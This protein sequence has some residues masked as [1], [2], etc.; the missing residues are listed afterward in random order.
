MLLVGGGD[1][2]TGG[3][4]VFGGS[5]ATGDNDV[6]DDGIEEAVGIGGTLHPAPPLATERGSSRRIYSNVWFPVDSP[7]TTKMCFNLGTTLIE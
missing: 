4:G 7:P 5:V 6:V 3:G 2:I 1:G